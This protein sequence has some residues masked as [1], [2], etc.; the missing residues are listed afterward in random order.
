MLLNIKRVF[1]FPLQSLS[2]TFLILEE[3]GEL[4]SKMPSGLYVKY[5]LFLSDF[6]ESW[7]FSTDFK[8]YSNIKLKNPFQYEPSCSMLTD[9]QSHDET[10]SRL[11]QFW[12][13]A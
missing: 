2:E 5:L 11:S 3:L 8:K 9:G 1:W 6:N 10:N 12:E 13:R 7:T 4:W